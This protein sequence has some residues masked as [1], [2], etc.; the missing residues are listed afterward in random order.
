[1]H[2]DSISVSDIIGLYYFSPL[3]WLTKK[4]GGEHYYIIIL[5]M[6]MKRKLVFLIKK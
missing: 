6:I 1:M 5:I 4:S 3:M 2:Q